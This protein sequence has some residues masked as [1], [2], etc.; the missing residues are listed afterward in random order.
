MKCI[1]CKDE[2]KESEEHIVPEALGNKKLITKRVCEKCN[3]RLGSNVDEYLTNHPLV[4]ILRINDNLLGKGGKEIKFFE[5]VETDINTGLK[6][7][8]KNNN[9][10][11]QPRIVE[12]NYGI[13]VEA[14]NPDDVIV[15][16]R[17][18]MNRK[19][20]TESQIDE[21]CKDAVVGKKE[22]K[23]PKFRKNASIN[24]AK[25]GLSAI[26]IAYEYAFEILG[27][28][29]LED[30]VAKL[31]SRELHKATNVNKKDI[32]PLDELA[33]FVTFPISGTG[34]DKILAEQRDT[35]NSAAMDILH[36]LFFIKQDNSFYC[37]INL[38][39]TDIISFAIKVTENADR[40][41]V[42]MPLTLIFRDGHADT[43]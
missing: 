23:S 7:S 3:N 16:F 18:Y 20:Y 11:L 38:C 26:K 13:R 22:L 42:K 1:I 6:Y 17:K 37:V 28:D 35:F 30:D 41:A 31:F 21:F 43:F 25:L 24:F 40:Y 9:P 10:V 14:S 27:E 33:R 36:T 4:K 19:G 29:Y 32:I 39:M 8:M 34:I 2:K 12:E 5:G 15:F